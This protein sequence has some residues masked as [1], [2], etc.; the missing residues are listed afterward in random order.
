MVF[1]VD[2]LCR[3]DPP[4]AAL[5]PSRALAITGVPPARCARHRAIRLA[6]TAGEPNA[7]G[8]LTSAR[9]IWGPYEE[10]W[11]WISVLRTNIAIFLK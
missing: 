9:T 11:L 6:A 1:S 3:R 5:A 2:R 8:R 4:H 7:N 10:E